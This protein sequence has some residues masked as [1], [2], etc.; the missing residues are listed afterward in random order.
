M[1]HTNS[2]TPPLTTP[3]PL[4]ILGD[5]PDQPTGLGRIGKDIAMIASTMPEFRVAY[6]GRGGVGR[7]EFPFHQYTFPESAQWGERYIEHVTH[8]WFKGEDGQPVRGVVLTVWDASRLEWFALPRQEA[9]PYT[10]FNTLNRGWF[11]KWGYFMVDG[12]GVD[13]NRLPL[14]QAEVISGF[15]RYLFAS[16]WA[17]GLARMSTP[18]L[19]EER[20][21][22][23]PHPIDTDVFKPFPNERNREVFRQAMGVAPTDLFIGCVMT[24]QARKH[25]STVIEACAIIKH[26]GIPVKLWLH[27]DIA[28]RYWNLEALLI[29]Y[30]LLGDVVGK[31]DSPMGDAHLAAKYAACDVTTLISG[32]EGFGYPIYESMACGTPVVTGSYGAGGQGV[33]WQGLVDPKHMYIDTMHNVRRAMYESTDVASAIMRT[34]ESKLDAHGYR[35]LV[36]HLGYDKITVLWKKWLRDG[37]ERMK[38]AREV[39]K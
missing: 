7:C 38:Q 19:V 10:L 6:M 3:T 23:L 39:S 5:G 29:E 28:T 2:Y 33:V 15:D 9:L 37:V 32:G 22:W 35:A 21:D 25:W 14:I 31:I 17:G 4:L 36:E 1:I 12:S 27:T 24:N 11:D 20:C 30:D 8:D 16:G 13:P 34:V 26:S 18:Q